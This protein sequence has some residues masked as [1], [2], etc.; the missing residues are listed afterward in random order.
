[1]GRRV[2]MGAPTSGG[3]HN[4]PRNCCRAEKS[5]GTSH[6]LL[7]GH[8]P[9]PS[10]TSVL[11]RRLSR[12]RARRRSEA[13]QGFDLQLTRYDERGWRATFYTSGIEHSPTRATSTGW[14][15]TPWHRTQRAAWEALRRAEEK[16]RLARRRTSLSAPVDARRHEKNRVE[17]RLRSRKTA[18]SWDPIPG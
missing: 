9:R 5:E 15:R 1:M 2:L 11:A 3:N 12:Q 8:R 6:A 10:S 16:N 7:P 17:R 18:L 14:E 13:L 4:T